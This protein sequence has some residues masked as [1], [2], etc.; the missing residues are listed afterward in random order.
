MFGVF[1]YDNFRFDQG[2]RYA[3]RSWATM[4]LTIA[5]HAPS[6]NSLPLDTFGAVPIAS[7]MN[8]HVERGPNAGMTLYVANNEV[9][10]SATLFVAG[11]PTASGS[12]PLFIEG[13]GGTVTAT[14]PLALPNVVV[15]AP[16]NSQTTLAIP[17]TSGPAAETLRLYINGWRP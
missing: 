14:A 5:G 11:L 2:L 1:R 4:P 6:S 9:G 8:L 16:T 7:T 3:T 13:F 12:S 17:K 10:G 15:P